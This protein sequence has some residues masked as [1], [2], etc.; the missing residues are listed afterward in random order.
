MSKFLNAIK[1]ITFFMFLASF[2]YIFY[3]SFYIDKQYPGSLFNP[4]SKIVNNQYLLEDANKILHKVTE[5][6]WNYLRLHTNMFKVSCAYL[7]VY[8][9][10]MCIRYSIYPNFKKLFLKFIN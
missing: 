5:Q 8:L 9:S 6:E 10:F 7:F 2:I 1:V 4:G 3:F